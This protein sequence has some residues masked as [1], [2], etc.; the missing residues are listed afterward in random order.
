M[1]DPRKRAS[2]VVVPD[3]GANAAIE[4]H[5]AAKQRE[6]QRD[7]AVGHFL[8]AVLGNVAHPDPP[9]L[10]RFRVDV[11]EAGTPGRDDPERRQP[12]H[13]FLSH[14]LPHEKADDVVTRPGPWPRLDRDIASGEQLANPINGKDGRLHDHPPGAG[15]QGV[16]AA[17]VS[18]SRSTVAAGPGVSRAQVRSAA[19][20]SGE[21][22]RFGI[23]QAV[24]S[25]RKS[26]CTRSTAWVPW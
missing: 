19:S 1:G 22:S 13:V 16:G 24:Q 11:V 9:S 3:S 4:D 6:Q 18:V 17:A 5:D 10:R 8:D 15:H 25:A 7:R 23:P 21:V 12:G 14:G 2:G 20:R 26:G